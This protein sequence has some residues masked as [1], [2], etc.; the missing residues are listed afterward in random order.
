MNAAA[1]EPYPLPAGWTL[2][3]SLPAG[4]HPHPR[5]AKAG[6]AQQRPGGHEESGGQEGL[7]CTGRNSIK[8]F[9]TEQCG[10]CRN[11][12]LPRDC[13]HGALNYQNFH[14]C[15]ILPAAGAAL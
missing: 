15:F 1:A 10:G 5:Q 13:A 11:G 6:G 7:S 2:T 14:C 3:L 9:L 8:S 4:R 12:V